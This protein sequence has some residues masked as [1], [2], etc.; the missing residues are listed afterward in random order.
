MEVR[1]KEVVPLN[2]FDLLDQ[3]DQDQVQ[4]LEE[5]VEVYQIQ[6][7]LRFLKIDLELPENKIQAS[8]E[9]TQV[10]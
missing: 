3:Q 7:S 4:N 1:L 2:L 9:L 5:R 10:V 8:I 6:H